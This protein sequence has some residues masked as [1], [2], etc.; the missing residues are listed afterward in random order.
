MT[1][2]RLYQK[3]YAPE[4]LRIATIEAVLQLASETLDWVRQQITTPKG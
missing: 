4:L 3:S 1:K 2:Q